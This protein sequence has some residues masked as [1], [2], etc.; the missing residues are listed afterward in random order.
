M[1]SCTNALAQSNA[2]QVIETTVANIPRYYRPKPQ[3]QDIPFAVFPDNECSHT[4][5]LSVGERCD[6]DEV[7]SMNSYT[8][9]PSLDGESLNTCDW[10]DLVATRSTAHGPPLTIEVG[11]MVPCIQDETGSPTSSDDF[12]ERSEDESDETS[13][14]T[15]MD[16]S[17]TEDTIS[18]NDFALS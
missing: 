9:H 16:F 17:Y 12:S 5:E 4:I 3:N 14:T 18:E 10:M 8:D 1:T 2:G 7:S 15:E 6:D 13:V 11:I